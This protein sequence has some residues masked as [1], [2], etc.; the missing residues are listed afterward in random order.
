MFEYA[1]EKLSGTD[2][3]TIYML[4]NYLVGRSTHKNNGQI[5][6]AKQQVTYAKFHKTTLGSCSLTN[7]SFER[8]VLQQLLQ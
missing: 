8:S 6:Y 7:V 1:H 5:I 4:S 3:I 2:L